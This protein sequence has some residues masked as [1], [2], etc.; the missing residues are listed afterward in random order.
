MR[1]SFIGKK[2]IKKEK[3]DRIFFFENISCKMENKKSLIPWVFSFMIVRWPMH[4]K[5]VEQSISTMPKFILILI[6][7]N[8]YIYIRTKNI[9]LVFVCGDFVFFHFTPRTL[10]LGAYKK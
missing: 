9:T 7:F 8:G 5:H 3:C 1:F 4:K 10:T 6:C 2:L